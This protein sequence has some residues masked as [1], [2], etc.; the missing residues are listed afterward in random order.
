[1]R[2]L[3]YLIICWLDGG[4]LQYYR[5]KDGYETLLSQFSGDVCLWLYEYPDA[6]TRCPSL[7]NL[8]LN[9]PRLIDEAVREDH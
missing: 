9:S 5:D 2:I 7:C 1:M 6:A 3:Y 8:Q 4:K